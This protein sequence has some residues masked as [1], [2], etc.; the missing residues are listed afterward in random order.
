[1]ASRLLRPASFLISRTTTSSSASLARF[2]ALHGP[3]HSSPSN[4]NNNNNRRT[5]ACPPLLFQHRS[6]ASSAAPATEWLVVV[7]DVPNTLAKRLQVRPT[8]FANLETVKKTGNLKFGGAILD[9]APSDPNDPTSFKFAGST[10]I[11]VAETRAD[12][13][14]FLESDV[15]AKE[16]VWDVP[17]AQIWALKTAIRIP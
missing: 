7:P 17:K 6:M 15:Y 12:V 2:T 5:A 16:G 8:H 1:M 9:E 3:L 11:L 4:R 13:V 14:A 10:L